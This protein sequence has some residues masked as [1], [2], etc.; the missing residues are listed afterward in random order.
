MVSVAYKFY[1][2]VASFVMR[3]PTYGFRSD[4]VQTLFTYN[5]PMP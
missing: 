3:S 5:I 2:Y 4:S 1:T